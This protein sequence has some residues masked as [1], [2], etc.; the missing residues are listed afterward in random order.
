MKPC[1]LKVCICCLQSSASQPF[2]VHGPLH[3]VAGGKLN[4]SRLCQI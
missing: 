2:T 1:H 3:R 4:A